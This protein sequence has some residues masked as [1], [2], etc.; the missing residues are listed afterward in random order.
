MRLP[1]ACAT[2]VVIAFNADAQTSD[3]VFVEVGSRV[4][5][6]SVFRP[7]AARVRVYRGDSLTAEWVNELTLG[8]SAGRRVMRWV[9]TGVRVAL[10]PN[11]PLTVLRQ[12]YD[13]VTLAPLGYWSTSSN[14][15]FTQLA[16][17]GTAVRGTRRVAG[18]TVVRRVDNLMP[19]LGFIA[20]AS[21]LVPVAAGLKAGMVLVAPVWG[22][23]MA[24]PDDRVFV[25]MRDTLVTVEGTPVRA[26]KVEERRREDRSLTAN[27]YLLTESPYMV[28]G[29][30][31]LPDGRIQRMTEVAEPI[32]R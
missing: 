31:P 14:G 29:E 10:V 8:D 3:T 12:T 21:D 2:L 25:V 4:I 11:R 28:Y 6:G 16:F 20:G 26:Q 9:T 30:V 19:R 17:D 27:W 13:A 23:N 32:R 24:A 7:H 1:F 18:D 5:D 15:A 22:P